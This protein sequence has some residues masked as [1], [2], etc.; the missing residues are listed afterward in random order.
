MTATRGSHSMNRH[1]HPV[2]R[3]IQNGKPLLYSFFCGPSLGAD[4]RCHLSVPPRCTPGC[5]PPTCCT[6]SCKRPNVSTIGVD[7]A[8][9]RVLRFVHEPSVVVTLPVGGARIQLACLSV[10][11]LSNKDATPCTWGPPAMIRTSTANFGA[12]KPVQSRLPS[13]SVHR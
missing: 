4:L 10:P 12:G 13:Q 9:S 8:E 7:T 2:D 3:E 5:R 6:S 1:H 11:E